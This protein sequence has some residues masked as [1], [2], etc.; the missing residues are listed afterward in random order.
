MK[1]IFAIIGSLGFFC[2]VGC[3]K[4]P[5]AWKK[6]SF[7]EQETSRDAVQATLPRSLWHKIAAVLQPEKKVVVEEKKHEG[8]EAEAEAPAMRGPLPSVFVPLKVYL[9]EKN[10]G[11]LARG[12][13]A[14]EFAAGGGELDLKDF[15]NSK[16]GSF[17]LVVEFMPDMQDISR[18]VFYLSNGVEKT[19]GRG[20]TVGAGCDTYFDLTK[21]FEKAMNHEGFLVN[22]HEAR[23]VHALA[24]TYFFAAAGPGKL[25]LAALTIKD[26]LHKRAQCRL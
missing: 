25:Y 18:R 20:E 17:Y 12:N 5:P 26:S 11:I 2:I 21:A 22:T 8:G 19:V 14:I 16:N 7:A 13:S 4:G 6:H 3:S 10:K 9:I 15:V 24:G 1:R 23:H